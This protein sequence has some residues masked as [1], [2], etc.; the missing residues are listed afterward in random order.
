MPVLTWQRTWLAVV[1]TVG[2]VLAGGRPASAQ[3]EFEIYYQMQAMN[4]ALGVG[5]TYCHVSTADKRVD[6]KADGNPKKVIARKMLAMTVDINARVWLAT[7]TDAAKQAAVGC[8][9]C[10]RGVPVPASMATIMSRTIDQEGP[11]AAVD[12]YRELRRRF[13]ERDVYDFTEGELLRIARLYVD[14]NPDAAMALAKMNL[15]WRPASAASYVVMAFAYTRK[16]DDASAIPLL[17]KALELDPDN[18]AARGYLLKLEE[19]QRM[20]ENR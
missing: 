5:C 12:R 16:L 18:G 10:H 13:Y 6:Y 1:L 11:A 17:R 14:S 20:R 7:G 4:E 15:D 2:L 3:K 9:S 19:F 8:V